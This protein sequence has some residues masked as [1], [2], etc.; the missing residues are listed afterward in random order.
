[1]A[2]DHATVAARGV[3]AKHR[4]LSAD[5]RNV[6][7]G[8]LFIAPWLVHFIVFTAYPLFASFYYSFTSF[9]ILDKPIWAGLANYKQMSLDRLVGKS[10]LNTAYYAI[11]AVPTGIIFSIIL[12]LLMNQK[13]AWRPLYRTI[14]Y[15]PTLVP[16]ISTAILWKWM[17]DTRYGLV[18]MGLNAIGLPSIPWFTSVEWSK[19]ALILMSW[20]G[21]GGGMLI[22]LAALQDVP[23]ELYDA[24]SIDGANLLRRIRHITLPLITPAIFFTLITGFIGASQYF[25]GA[26][27]TT[28]GGP[29]DSTLMYGLYLYRIA[30]ERFDMGYGCTLAWILFGVIALLTLG[31]F[32][33][34]GRWVFYGG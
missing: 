32:R 17:L 1:M 15:I 10:I 3:A 34:S 20:W 12:A 21:A 18:N 29:A 27:F 2:S 33:S 7:I 16:S 31:L 8:L 23:R 5:V 11:L 22:Y 14:F 9:R 6:P 30:F 26:F 25:A 4:H 24:A 28:R 19:P 13:L